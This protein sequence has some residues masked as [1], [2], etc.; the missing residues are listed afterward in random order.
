MSPSLA[1]ADLLSRVERDVQRAAQRSRNGLRYA[2]GTSRPKVGQTPK[3]V[4]WRRHKAE[5]WRYRNDDVRYRP[6]LVIVHSLVSRSYVLDLYPGNSAVAFLLARRASTSSCSTGASPDEADAGNTLETYVDDGIPAAIAAACEAAGTDD[7]TLL[8]Y[9]FGGVLSLL[10]AARHP[11]L[12]IRNL[13]LMATPVDFDEMETITALVRDGRL[14]P[15]DVIE[16]TGNVPPDVIENGFRLLKPTAEVTQYAN[17]WENLWNDEFMEGYQ[18]MGQW[19]RDHVPFP[20][21]AFRQTVEQ[22]VRANALMDGTLELGG[23]KV[24]LK[25]IKRPVLNIMAER[26]HIVPLAAAEPLARPRRLGGDG[27][28]AAGRRPRRAWSPGRKAAKVTLPGIAGW[29]ADHSEEAVMEIRDPDPDDLDA[30]LDFFERVPEAERTFFKEH[31]LDRADRRGLADGRP[32]R[33]ARSRLRRRQRR[34]LRRRRAALRL[35]GP[36]R[37]A[38]AWSSTPSGAGRGLGRALAR[39]A[40]L[41]ALELR[42]DASSTVEVVAEQEGAVAM[43]R[44]LGFQAEGLLRDHVRDR[45]GELRDLVLLAHPIAD[46]WSAMETAGID[47]AVT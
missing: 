21:A 29:I 9:C 46:Q 47:D 20:G 40:L 6:P 30:L 23:E 33:A 16:P 45:D 26:D 13:A 35:V 2:A 31:V 11:E 24:D 8:G 12:P 15:E 32:R 25:A 27:G 4:V 36:R 10:S 44:A 22:L 41:Q 5:L 19:A 39:W 17:L 7:V 28:A 34:R 1:P 43:F 3:D 42:A 38:S 18:A 37:R 14:D